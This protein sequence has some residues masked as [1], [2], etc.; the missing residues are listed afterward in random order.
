M[1]KQAKTHPKPL[2]ILTFSLQVKLLSD[3]ENWDSGSELGH[4]DGWTDGPTNGQT[5]SP[6]DLVTYCCVHAT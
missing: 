2:E 6:I 3:G 5:D 1:R 4:G